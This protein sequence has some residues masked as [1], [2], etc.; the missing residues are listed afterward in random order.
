QSTGFAER[1]DGLGRIP[2]LFGTPWSA[3]IDVFQEWS[4]QLGYDLGRYGFFAG[5]HR[6]LFPERIKG[7]RGDLWYRLEAQNYTHVHPTLA[8]AH[9]TPRPQPITRTP[10][11]LPLHPPP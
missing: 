4:E 6:D 2:L 11:L 9:V 3:D 10:P 7:L 5:I 8:S 1:T